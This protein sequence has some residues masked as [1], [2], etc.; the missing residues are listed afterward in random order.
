[1]E[2]LINSS[3]LILK[4]LLITLQVSVLVLLIGTVIGIFGGLALTYG[5]RPLR[6]LVRIYVDTIRGIPL[7][8]LI[9]A[10]FYGFPVLG[11]RTTAV[12]AGVIALSVFCGAHVSE[13]IRGGI[14]SIPRG[15][16]DAAKAIGLTFRQR[17]RYVIF[18]QAISRILPP[19]INTAVELVKA[20]SLV[21]LVSVVD[22]MLAIQ[23]IVGRTRETLFFYGVAALLYFAMNYTISSIGLR[24]EKRFA[25]TLK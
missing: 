21:S 11:I 3:G 24:L 10:I 8:I 14:N 15:Q 23:Q 6:W 25:Y 17:L 5:A 13:V 4:G 2:S 9:F 22:L 1:M 20:S 16:T 7:L 19:W 18:P 12:I